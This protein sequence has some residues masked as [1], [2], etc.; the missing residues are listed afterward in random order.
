[1]PEARFRHGRHTGALVPL[2]SIPSKDSWGIGEITDL[3]RFAVWLRQA[4]LDF[5]MLLP[6][7]EMG[8]GQHSPYSALSAM[9]IDPIYIAVAAIEEV[10]GVWLLD[11]LSLPAGAS[12]GFVTGATMANVTALAAARHEMLRRAGVGFGSLALASLLSEN[13][14]AETAPRGTTLLPRI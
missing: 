1:M 7:N 6:V 5:V 10:T 8:E 9:A 11:L 12:I 4:A 14:R 3:P 13:G 2:F